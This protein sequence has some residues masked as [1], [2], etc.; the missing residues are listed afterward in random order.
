[1]NRMCYI[2]SISGDGKKNVSRLSIMERNQ[3]ETNQRLEE[4]MKSNFN[5]QNM[6]ANILTNFTKAGGGGQCLLRE[7]RS[8]LPGETSEKLKQTDSP[9][10][11]DEGG[12]GSSEK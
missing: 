11:K 4:M 1:M 5:L 12:A 7:E 3:M 10:D 8:I 9:I 2:L 6:L